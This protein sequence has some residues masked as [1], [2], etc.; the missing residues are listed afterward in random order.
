MKRFSKLRVK[1]GIDGAQATGKTTLHQSLRARLES[2]FSFIPEASR[3]IA[4]S[5]GVHSAA[6]WVQLLN[7]REMLG[8]FFSAEE[9]WLLREEDT[10]ESYIVDS[11]LW[12][13]AAYRRYFGY[14]IKIDILR[15]RC[16]DLLLYCPLDAALAVD[17]GFRFLEGQREID[18]IYRDLADTHFS[19]T[20]VE[21]PGIAFRTEAAIAAISAVCGE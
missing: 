8:A 10:A 2:V 4:P 19:G 17:D 3:V 7:N 18:M 21:L 11:S 13:T 6:D 20:F 1:I 9:A 5:F 14:E 16:Y 12:L 15:M